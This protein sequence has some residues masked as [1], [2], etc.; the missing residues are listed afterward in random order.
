M[1]RRDF[2]ALIGG[3]AAARPFGARAQQATKSPQIGVLS[4][5]RGDKSDASLT[6]LDAFVSALRELG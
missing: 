5:G 2:I 3:A 4:L 6:T 1:R